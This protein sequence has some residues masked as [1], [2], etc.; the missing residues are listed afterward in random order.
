VGEHGVARHKNFRPGA[1]DVA[2]GLERNAAID[3]DAKFQTP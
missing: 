3:F 2:D 1:H